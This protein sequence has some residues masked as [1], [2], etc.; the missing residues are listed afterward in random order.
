M[1]CI[2]SFPGLPH[3]CSSVCTIHGG[4]TQ[5]EEQNRRRPGNEAMLCIDHDYTSSH[6]ICNM[7]NISD[8]QI[9]DL[10]FMKCSSISID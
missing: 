10:A 2:A 3:L 9:P 1:C 4:R 6:F 5:I 8:I 7:Y